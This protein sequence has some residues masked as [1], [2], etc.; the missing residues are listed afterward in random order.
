MLGWN[1]SVY[2][3]ADNRT[4]PATKESATNAL[5]LFANPPERA[6]VH[7]SSALTIVGAIVEETVGAL[8]PA[9]FCSEPRFH[10][11]SQ[12]HPVV[13]RGFL[14]SFRATAPSCEI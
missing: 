7:L 12:A 2:R 9:P 6:A 5:R 10:N 13:A 3:Q 14:N 4:S 8:V 11:G 1:L